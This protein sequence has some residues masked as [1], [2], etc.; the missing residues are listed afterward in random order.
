MHARFEQ[1]IEAEAA[2]R[3]HKS[4]LTIRP[5][6]HQKEDRVLGHILVCFV[7]DVLW[8]TLSQWCLRAGPE[9]RKR[10]VTRPTDHQAILLQRLGLRLPTRP[11]ADM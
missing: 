10:C 11:M 1:R 7:A 3:I 6:W 5:I 2:F 8:K 9:I 4:D